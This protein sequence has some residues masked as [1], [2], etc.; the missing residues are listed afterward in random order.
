MSG[1]NVRVTLFMHPVITL[2]TLN[3]GLPGSFVQESM[4]MYPVAGGTVRMPKKD[5]LLAG[6]H[7]IP[8]NTTVFLPVSSRALPCALAFEGN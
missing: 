8:K 6:K 1:G 2:G 4:R 5:V 7:L 3:L